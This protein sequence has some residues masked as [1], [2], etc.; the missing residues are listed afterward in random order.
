[1]TFNLK[2]TSN[3]S[4]YVYSISGVLV[5]T[6]T[7]KNVSEGAQTIKIDGD[8]L[9]NG[10]YIVKLIAGKQNDTVKFIKR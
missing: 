9:S 2:E 5:K 7:E 6:I 10:T 4:V 1:M 8:D 3:V